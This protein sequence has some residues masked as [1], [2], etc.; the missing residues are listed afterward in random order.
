[1]F[2]LVRSILP[3]STLVSNLSMSRQ[4]GR[5]S[6]APTL[7]VIASRVPPTSMS[8]KQT[9]LIPEGP[10]PSRHR[11]PALAQIS[12]AL[13]SLLPAPLLKKLLN[14]VTG[15]LNTRIPS[16]TLTPCRYLT[17]R[18]SVR[19]KTPLTSWK[20]PTSWRTF[21]RRLFRSSGLGLPMALDLSG[22]L[23]AAL[24]V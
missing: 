8:D 2:T 5:P 1:M 9:T 23:R 19:R 16:P 4:S 13:V 17:D 21:Q 24:R 22:T 14:P 10:V 20:S 11:G 12:L 6:T 15:T 7:G 18:R 3:L